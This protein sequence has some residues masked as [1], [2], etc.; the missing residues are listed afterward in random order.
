[1][2]IDPSIPLQGQ[3][4]KVATPEQ[5][6]SLQSLSL[7]LQDQQEARRVKNQVLQLNQMPGTR[8]PSGVY[9]D[10]GLMALG[11]ISPQLQSAEAQHRAVLLAQ[12]SLQRQREI[13]EQRAKDKMGEGKRREILTA[14]Y[15][16]YSTSPGSAEQKQAAFRKAIADQVAEMKA[17]GEG[18]KY[19]WDTAKLDHMGTTYPSVD[20]ALAFILPAEKVVERGE[21][22]QAAQ[23]E[24]GMPLSEVSK[25]P[26]QAPGTV[27]D[28]VS[29]KDIPQSIDKVSGADVR[30]ID[31]TPIQGEPIAEEDMID[32]IDVT[33]KGEQDTPTSLRAQAKEREAAAAR[34]KKLGTKVGFEQAKD[35][36]NR[37]KEYRAAALALDKNIEDENELK[38]VPGAPGVMYDPSRRRFL[39]DGEPI[40]AKQVQDISDRNRA[41]GAS[42]I[43]LNNPI[44]VVN[45]KTGKSELVQ[46]GKHGEVLKSAYSPQS[47]EGEKLSSGYYDRM[48]AAEQEMVSVG[49]TGY[50]TFGTAGARLAGATA[51]RVVMTPEQQRYKQAQSDWVRAKLRKESGAVI[52]EEEMREEIRTYFPQP[53]DSQAVI[54]QKERA[55][56]VA[57]SAMGRNAGRAADLP[58]VKRGGERV[59]PIWTDEDEKRLMELERK[60]GSE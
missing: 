24:T 44:A 20:D 45:P 53:G 6:V 2:P 4:F 15:N 47:T 22:R 52:A 59:A 25:A 30:G 9:T 3:Q 27:Q 28:A 18:L 48:Q 17:S 23:A 55:R 58:P 51:E 19:G 33:A 1:M 54:K 40:D 60:R 12:E 29:L 31:T 11:K 42:N 14:A 21:M 13:E 50:P 32:P 38:L 26:V 7:Q 35:A 57:V 49:P 37:A 8:S 5:M 34:L 16:T 10:Q 56:A 41:A 36:E 39:L 43:N 46:F